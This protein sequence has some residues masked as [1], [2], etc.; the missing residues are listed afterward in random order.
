MKNKLQTKQMK[1][2]CR[3]LAN[4]K[5]DARH[6]SAQHPGLSAQMMLL[7]AAVWSYHAQSS[8]IP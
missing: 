8:V 6:R 2:V 4:V 1:T 7:A 3:Y 5:M